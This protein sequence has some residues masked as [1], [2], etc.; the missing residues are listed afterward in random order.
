M[1][2]CFNITILGSS[3]STVLY[4][5]SWTQVVRLER[6]VDFFRTWLSRNSSAAICSPL[7]PLLLN[8]WPSLQKWAL[9]SFK[10]KVDFSGGGKLKNPQNLLL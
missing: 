8:K 1:V 9:V 4:W 7:V 5:K 2:G 6:K 10:Q 3:K